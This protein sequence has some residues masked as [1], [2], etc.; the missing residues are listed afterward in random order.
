MFKP[1]GGLD[2]RA[3][4]GTRESS[5]RVNTRTN[6]VT[7]TRDRRRLNPSSAAMKAS[8]GRYSKLVDMGI[9]WK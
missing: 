8:G 7:V 6:A 4:P 3:L 5:E 2:A 9:I 1:I